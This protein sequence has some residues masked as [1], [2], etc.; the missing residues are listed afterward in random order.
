ME[1]FLVLQ[2]GKPGLEVL[3]TESAFEGSFLSV[4]DHVFLKMRPPGEGL[5]T[6]CTFPAFTLPLPLGEKLLNVVWMK[7]PDVLGQS[8]LA[9]VEFVTE[10]TLVLLLLEGGV[11]GVFLLVDGQIGLGGVALK[12]DLTLEWLLSCV[13]SG[14]TFIFSCSVKGLV[15]FWTLQ[16][17][18]AGSLD[19][20][21]SQ[22]LRIHRTLGRASSL[23]V[24]HSL[25]PRPS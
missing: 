18:F 23:H 8:F 9:G 10:R 19:D 3:I 17:L 5:Q 22:T 25:R 14:V 24:S 2:S 1:L 16:G 20:D 13:H 15:T 4:E 6:N 21:W 11:G 7:P 12:T